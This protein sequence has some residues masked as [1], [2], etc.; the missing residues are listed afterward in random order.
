MVICRI[1]GISLRAQVTGQKHNGLMHVN[2]RIVEDT[3]V[4]HKTDFSYKIYVNI[5]FLLMTHA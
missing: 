5:D 1:S 2:K 3:R 4:R